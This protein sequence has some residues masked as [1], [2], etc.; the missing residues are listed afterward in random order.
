MKKI[1][2]ETVF[3]KFMKAFFC[4]IAILVP[5]VLYVISRESILLGLATASPLI[6]MGLYFM[7]DKMLDNARENWYRIGVRFETM[8][9]K[10]ERENYEYIDG[11]RETATDDEARRLRCLRGMSEYMHENGCSWNDAAEHIVFSY[12]KY[13]NA[14]A[15]DWW[16]VPA[17]WDAILESLKF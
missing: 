16:E 1:S 7:W 17:D 3:D 8:A 14:D 15:H 2:I 11:L 9:D 6:C 4:V 5:F 12:R 10:L 13:Y